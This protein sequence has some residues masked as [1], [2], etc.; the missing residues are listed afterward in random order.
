MRGR[1]RELRMAAH[2][3][4]Q[5]T[6]STG[7]PCKWGHL[8]PRYVVNGG[9]SQCV[10]GMNKLAPNAVTKELV[11]WQPAPVHV[12]HDMLPQLRD[13]LN[14]TI[15]QAVQTWVGDM[16]MMTLGRVAG[17][18]QHQFAVE[19]GRKLRDVQAAHIAKVYG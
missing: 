8:A 1:I 4:G 9:C 7:E 16:G 6:F 3:L 17:Y 18:K 14:D 5:K 15:A 2:A 13:A 10:N 11:P 12:P 19:Q